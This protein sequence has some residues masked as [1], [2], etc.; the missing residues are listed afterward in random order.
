MVYLLSGRSVESRSRV[1]DVRATGDVDV[2]DTRPGGER[3][4]LRHYTAFAR[5]GEWEVLGNGDHIVPIAEDLAAG[6]SVKRAVAK[7]TYEPDVPIFTPRIWIAASSASPS[8]WWIGSITRMSGESGRARRLCQSVGALQP[9]TGLVVTTYDSGPDKAQTSR[10]LVDVTV[11]AGTREEL[12]QAA[13]D[14]LRPE[15]RV[16]LLGIVPGRPDLNP[17]IRTDR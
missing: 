4:A 14:M 1:L 2:V 9:G 17:L 12:V 15:L 7:H 10:T 8:S 11:S 16:A 13:W 5:R 6:V 3:D